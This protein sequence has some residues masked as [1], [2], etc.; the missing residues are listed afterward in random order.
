MTEQ[1]GLT[2]E[3][4]ADDLDTVKTIMFTLARQYERIDRTVDRVTSQQEVNTR[5]ISDLTQFMGQLGEAMAITQSNIRQMQSDIRQMQSD[6]R[7]MQSDIREM[8]SEVKGL[9]VEN[10][11]ILQRVLGDEFF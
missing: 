8:Q 1:N 5:A 2:L 7:E 6:I 3:G 10:R 11:R 4:V 9:Q